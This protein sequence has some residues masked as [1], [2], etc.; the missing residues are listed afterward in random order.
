MSK[1]RIFIVVMATALVLVLSSFLPMILSQTNNFTL[2]CTINTIGN[3]W[4]G[5]VAFDLSN[6]TVNAL[7]VINTDGTMLSVRES[8][9]SYGPAYNI[10]PD[11]LMFEGEPQV[12]S[13]DTAWPIWATNF[14][15]LTSNTIEPF[16]D[17]LSEHDLQYDPVNNTFLTLQ[18]YVRQ[19]GNNQILMD[20]IVQ[21]DASG[22]VLWSWDTYNYIPLSEAS[23]YNQTNTLPNGQTV[24]DFTHA[25][26]I[27]WDYNNSIIYLNLR[28]ENTFYAI[29]QTTGN[30]I[31]ACG[32]FGNFTLL[33]ANG[34]PLP[35]VNG[36]NG[37]LLPPSLWYGSHDVKEVTPD[38]F[39]MFDNDYDNNSNPINCHSEMLEVTLNQTSM[40]AYVSWSWVAPI[41]Y[42]NS[43][44]GATLLLPNGDFMGDFGDPTHQ[45]PQNSENGQNLSWNFTNTGAV[46]V[47]V[48]PAGQ[49]VRTWTFPVGW[50]VYRIEDIT[51]PTSVIFPTPTPTPSPVATSTPPIATPTPA[52][53]ATLTPSPIVTSTPSVL[54]SATPPSAM[55]SQTIIVS[56]ALIVVVV[57]VVVLAAM[58]Y[59]RKRINNP[60]IEGTIG[61]G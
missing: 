9:G 2:P 21:V 56:I 59:M 28:N 12:G 47:E 55:N 46:F 49:V 16:S 32:E 38:V 17:V 39:T 42:W 57:V 53:A 60:K 54:P 35:S 24:E 29:N 52:P 14:W 4:N 31:W 25:N 8:A 40:T 15:N 33:G 22:N 6:T 61:N 44:G 34:Q 10:A 11:T 13:S 5:D 18:D 45:L 20:K 36:P 48:N 3:A 30:I 37:T 43:Y 50:Y 23:P 19:V 26:S 51:D 7:V 1:K 41:Q 58:F 27:D